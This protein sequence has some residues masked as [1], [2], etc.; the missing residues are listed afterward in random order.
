VDPRVSE[1][2]RIF[3][4]LLVLLIGLS[5]I[6]LMRMFK[7]ISNLIVTLEYNLSDIKSF[8][9]VLVTVIFVFTIAFMAI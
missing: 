5:L 7:S 9:V 6:K 8:M 2:L 4:S 1:G 3:L